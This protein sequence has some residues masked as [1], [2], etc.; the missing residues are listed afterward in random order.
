MKFWKIFFKYWIK[1][2]APF[3]LLIAPLHADDNQ[4]SLE[5]SGDNFSLEIDQ[6]GYNN[7]VKML[8]SASYINNAPNLAIHIIQYNY[9]SAE[10]IIAFDEMSGSGN[11]IKLGQGIAWDNS[12][13]GWTYDSSEGGGHYMELDL[14]GNDNSLEWHQTNSGSTNGHDFN[15]HLAGDDNNISGRQQNDGSK[16]MNLTIYND[17]NNVLLRQKGSW[18]AHTANI[19]LDGLYGTDLEFRQLGTTSQSYTLSQNCMTV[20]GCTLSIQQGN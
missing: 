5:Q 2:W 14:Y 13:I 19:T 3:I 12:T 16:T 10:N 7:T 4:I 1:P 8:D 17:E 6:V 20:G 15:F 11:S 18:S 9:T